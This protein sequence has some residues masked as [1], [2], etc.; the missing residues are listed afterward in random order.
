M[1][2]SVFESF[3]IFRRTLGSLISTNQDTFFKNGA[4]LLIDSKISTKW[5]FFLIKMGF[6][7]TKSVKYEK[8]R[9]GMVGLY[10]NVIKPF[11]NRSHFPLHL[12]YHFFSNIVWC[13][14]VMRKFHG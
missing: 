10:L 4:N 3:P 14:R 9:P 1:S 12:R 6:H 2:P 11:L 7:V 13:G 5:E 8:T